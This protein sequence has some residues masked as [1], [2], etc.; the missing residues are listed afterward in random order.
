MEHLNISKP[1]NNSHSNPHAGG[2]LLTSHPPFIVGHGIRLV[3]VDAEGHR[4]QL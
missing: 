4:L 2:F 1:L 3:L